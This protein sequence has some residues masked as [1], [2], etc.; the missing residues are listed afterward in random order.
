ML[1]CIQLHH[2]IV[3][4]LSNQRKQIILKQIKIH[5]KWINKQQIWIYLTNNNKLSL[6]FSNSNSNK[7]IFF[8]NKQLQ[9]W[10][11]ILEWMLF[12]FNNK[13][14]RNC[15]NRCS[16]KWYRWL[17]HN[18]NNKLK[19]INKVRTN[20]KHLQIITIKQTNIELGK[21][22]IMR[23]IQRQVRLNLKVSQV[24]KKKKNKKKNNFITN[25]SIFF[26]SKNKK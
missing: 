9:V 22:R 7:C 15:N 13:C 18:N 24:R 6:N 12:Y 1:I 14:N 21:I 8:N 25:Y 10:L 11:G 19:K 3:N 26:I 2:L 20:I 17:Q 23:I 4:Q 16:N 5:K